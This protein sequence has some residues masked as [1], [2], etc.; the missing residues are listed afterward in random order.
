[1]DVLG[2]VGCDFASWCRSF[3]LASLVRDFRGELS[4]LAG[5]WWVNMADI[6]C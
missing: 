1:M 5:K 6:L 2:C 4:G 3:E